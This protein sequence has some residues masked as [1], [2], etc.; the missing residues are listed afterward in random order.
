MKVPIFLDLIGDTPLIDLT[1]LVN[2]NYIY[3]YAKCEFMNPSF[4]LKDRMARYI[5]DVAEAQG[6][7]KRGDVIV[8]SSSGNTGC[9]FAMLGKIRGYHIVIVTSEKC[10]IEKQNHKNLRSTAI[11]RVKIIIFK[12]LLL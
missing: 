6:Q 2:K 3:L 8:C 7:L 4:S 10:S 9:S 1:K 5:L 11:Y 12:I